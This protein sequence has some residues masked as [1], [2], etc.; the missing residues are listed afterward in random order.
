[1]VL[2]RIYKDYYLPLDLYTRLK[3][4][5]RYNYNQDIDELNNFVESL[6]AKLNVEVSLFIHEKT[7]RNI[8]FLK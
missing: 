1:M 5:L 2:N 8:N 7:Y 3:Q 6:P 4:S